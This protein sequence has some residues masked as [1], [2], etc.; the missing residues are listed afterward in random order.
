MPGSSMTMVPTR[1]KVSRNAAASAGRKEMST[2]IRGLPADDAGGDSQHLGVQ[3][4]AMNGSAT[5]SDRNIA[6]IFGTKA[7]VISGSE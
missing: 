6:R 4:F 2:R 7:M 5:S 3:F 1:A